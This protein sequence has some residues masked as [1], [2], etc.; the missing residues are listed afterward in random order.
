VDKAPPRS[1]WRFVLRT[2]REYDPSRF[3]PVA[4][5]FNETRESL[6]ILHPDGCRRP[7]VF[8]T[9]ENGRNRLL[10]LGWE[11]VTEAWDAAAQAPAAAAEEPAA[12]RKRPVAVPIRGA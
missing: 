9:D 8:F 5:T 1:E 6:D 7:T 4:N 11:D 3:R 12:T 2:I 10:R